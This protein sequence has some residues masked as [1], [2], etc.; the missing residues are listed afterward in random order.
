[1]D[2]YYE[3]AKNEYGVRYIRCMASTVKEDPNTNNL[4][5]RYVTSSGELVDEEFEMVVL[6]VGLKPSSKTLGTANRLGVNLNQYGFCST[7]TF[8]PI[9]TS[10]EGIYVCGASSEPK[11]I[12]EVV[13]QASGAAACVGELLQEVRGTMMA[14]KEYPS[15]V[16]VTGQLPR[17]GVFVCRCGI[18]IAGVV[19]VPQVV[20]YAKSLP[21]VVCTEEKIYVCS[22]DSQGL[23]REKIREHNLN[24]VVV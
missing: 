6:S 21:D 17:I 2:T 4:T 18:N 22:Q 13:C 10:K 24:R 14:K 3:R 9:A 20:E 5:I 19:D 11:D 1:F 7:S 8:T 16:D 12:P 23:I 15:E